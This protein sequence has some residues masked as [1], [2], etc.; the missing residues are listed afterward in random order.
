[1]ASLRR[2][3]AAEIEAD[4]GRFA[5]DAQ[6]PMAGLLVMTR[7]RIILAFLQAFFPMF[8]KPPKPRRAERKAPPKRRRGTAK[9]VSKTA[10]RSRAGSPK[11]KS[12]RKAAKVAVTNPSSLNIPVIAEEKSS[13][14][15]K[16]GAKTTK[17]S[18]PSHVRVITIGQQ[19]GPTFP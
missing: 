2:N 17:T 19:Q 13:R 6:S 18:T 3:L 7:V 14:V 8:I 16:V 4:L 12:V 11:R 5:G 15:A 10:T 1:M 9:A